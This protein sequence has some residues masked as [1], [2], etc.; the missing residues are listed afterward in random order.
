MLIVTLPSL[1]KTFLR[2]NLLS[3]LEKLRETSNDTEINM[4]LL[5][6]YDKLS[7]EL[8]PEDIGNRI[9]PNLIPMLISA[10]L[11]KSQFQKL[12]STIRTLLTQIEKHREKDLEEIEN[13]GE[14]DTSNIDESPDEIFKQFEAATGDEP[15]FEF[16]NM[17]EGKG[18]GTAANA[19]KTNLPKSGG[20]K[21]ATGDPIG[22]VGSAPMKPS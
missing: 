5:T 8:T 13:I 10:S 6:L 1:D 15:G 17:F 7:E 14:I 18:V 16:L 19:P 22:G 3:S 11:T 9:L 4:R 21:P 20:A 12:L 2:E